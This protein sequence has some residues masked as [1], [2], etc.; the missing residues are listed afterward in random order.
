M[1]VK[2]G[3]E[4]LNAT[5]SHVGCIS[6]IPIWAHANPA[7]SYGPSTVPN[8]AHPGFCYTHCYT[9]VTPIVTLILTPIS[10]IKQCR[11]KTDRLTIRAIAI[12]C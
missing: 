8:H 11:I 3:T 4:R 6:F 9:I 5:P 2:I 7:L 12:V 1:V 10:T